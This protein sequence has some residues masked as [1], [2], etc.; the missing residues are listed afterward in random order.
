MKKTGIPVNSKPQI[1]RNSHCV[2]DWVCFH[3]GMKVI[4]QAVPAHVTRVSPSFPVL[5]Y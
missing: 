5:V 1:S 2:A 3:I 4:K